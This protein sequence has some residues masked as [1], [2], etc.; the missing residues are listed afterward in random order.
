MP[1]LAQL[2]LVW[3]E[4]P[5]EDLPAV[6]AQREAV[7]KAVRDQGYRYVTLDLEG[8]PSGN[9]NDGNT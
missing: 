5:V 2:R 3:L 4:V 8:F 7:V 9:L 6:L 1:L